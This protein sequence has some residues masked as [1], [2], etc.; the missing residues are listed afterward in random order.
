[1]PGIAGQVMR[2]VYV[3]AG[4]VTGGA[5]R[6]RSLLSSGDDA[7]WLRE[8]S[9]AWP[10][11]RPTSW[12]WIHGASVGEA[13]IALALAR[14]IGGR[15]AGTHVVV[16]SATR[17]GRAR[18]QREQSV[19]SRVFPI[20]YAPFVKRILAPSAP[21]LFVAIETEIWPETLRLLHDRGVPVVFAN[22]RI[23]DRSL[24]RYRRLAP[25]VAPLLARVAKVCARDADAAAKWRSLGVPAAAVHVTGNIKFDLAA[26]MEAAD[27]APL[28]ERTEGGPLLLAASTHDGE[29]GIALD[30]F[31]SV[32]RRTP[33]ARL[34]LAP[35]HPTRAEAV[36]AVAQSKGLA[37]VALGSADT[38]A[39]P[40]GIDAVVL[41]RLGLLLR[42]YAGVRAAFVGGSLV[43]GP[44]GHNL[45]EP[46]VAGCPVAAGPHLENVED[47]RELLAEAGALTVVRNV[48]QLATFWAEALASPDVFRSKLESARSAAGARRGALERTVREILPLLSDERRVVGARP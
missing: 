32:R 17:A 23:S 42:A 24:P 3:L 14:A 1:M 6:A 33:N 10:G 8:R 2:S 47:Q 27:A 9:G 5:L 16:T 41:D 36:V 31:L 46:V 48:E 38:A 12:I 11:A 18:V 21:R 13:D 22:A 20:D 7:D 37:A 19:E 28:F 29:D 45:L 15:A 26:G 44:G 43:A 35:R 30:A 34:V 40:D 25:L 4:A 39:W